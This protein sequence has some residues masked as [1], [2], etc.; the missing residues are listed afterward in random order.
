MKAKRSSILGLT[1]LVSTLSRGSKQTQANHEDQLPHRASKSGLFSL[2]RFKKDKSPAD[3]HHAPTL[4][5]VDHYDEPRVPI[6]FES[7]NEMEVKA[8]AVFARMNDD[9]DEEDGTSLSF[10]D[11]ED[12]ILHE[13]ND[14]P[15]EKIGVRDANAFEAKAAKADDDNGDDLSNKLGAFYPF[16]ESRGEAEGVSSTHEED[17]HSSTD[18]M[19]VDDDRSI[20]LETSCDDS[21]A[22]CEEQYFKSNAIDDERDN[23]NVLHDT[24]KVEVSD[25]SSRPLNLTANAESLNTESVSKNLQLSSVKHGDDGD[26]NDD[27]DD[28]DDIISSYHSSRFDTS[29]SSVSLSDNDDDDDDVDGTLTVGQRKNSLSENKNLSPGLTPASMSSSGSDVDDYR[30]SV[31]VIGRELPERVDAVQEEK[32]DGE[33]PLSDDDVSSSDDDK[34]KYANDATELHSSAVPQ[35]GENEDGY[36]DS[37]YDT[38]LVVSCKDQPTQMSTPIVRFVDFCSI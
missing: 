9:S 38:I 20:I 26:D 16:K 22:Q 25:A 11:D 1:R 19:P 32:V 18:S 29:P 6:A 10:N 30:A 5:S 35:S 36:E 12:T 34:I 14:E 8:R 23:S 3:D 2:K 28:D 7:T 4:A 27:D 33:Y 37:V 21:A 13:S 24:Y 15:N 17:R 31:S